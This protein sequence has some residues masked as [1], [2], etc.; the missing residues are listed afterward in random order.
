M[1]N[2]TVCNRNCWIAA[3]VLGLIVLV[4]SAGLGSMGFAGGL[5]LGLVTAGLVGA[6]LVWLV[7]NGQ[8]AVDATRPAVAPVQVNGTVESAAG[9]APPVAPLPRVDL[10]ALRAPS[11][12]VAGATE[13]VG[14]DATRARTGAPQAPTFGAPAQA[15]TGAASESDRTPPVAQ[16][17]P[18]ADTRAVLR[19]PSQSENHEMPGEVR[20][21]RRT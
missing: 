18:E 10:S 8:P 16:D 7:C 13:D 6:A 19:S 5:F 17:S 12:I 9:V 1:L 21:G 3:A 2:R 4:L 20:P 15:A 11:G 14:P